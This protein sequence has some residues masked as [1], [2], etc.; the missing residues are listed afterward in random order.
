MPKTTLLA[1]D[2]CSMQKA[3]TQE[4][5]PF[6]QLQKWPPRKG[7]SLWKIVSFAQKLKMA[8]TCE[9]DSTSTLQLFYAKNGSKKPLI[10][11]KWDHLENWQKWP[12]SIGYGLYKM[13]SWAQ[14]LKMR[15]I[16]AKRL[17]KNFTVAL[18][19]NLLQ[20]T[21]NIREM[22][23]FWKLQ[24]WPPRKVYSLWK[25]VNLAQKLKMAKTCEKRLY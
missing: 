10:F 2:S 17:Y 21:A 11:E 15:K 12:L 8:K 14:K 6:W 9:N 18:C 5:R 24:K 23:P 7:Y 1:L 3:N 22:S 16:C 4:M 19:K 20:K 13:A 25:I